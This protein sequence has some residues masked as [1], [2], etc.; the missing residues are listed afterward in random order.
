[1][2]KNNSACGEIIHAQSTQFSA[3]MWDWQQQISQASLVCIEREGITIYGL[4]Y[5][6]QTAPEQG[7]TVFPY[8][9]TREELIQHHPE[10]FAFLQ[11]TLS[12]ITVGYQDNKNIHHTLPPT[13]PQPHDFIRVATDEE[14]RE[15]CARSDY[16]HSIFSQAHTIQ[17]IDEILLCLLQRL[18]ERNLITQ[19]IDNF[20]EQ[21]MLVIGSDYRRLKLFLSRVEHLLR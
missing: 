19:I 1:M 11:T 20:V 2:M 10:I 9:M 16:L 14:W 21:Y 17:Y 8:R 18:Q 12:C 4:I 7:R 6:Q 5:N 3:R 13:P 15:F